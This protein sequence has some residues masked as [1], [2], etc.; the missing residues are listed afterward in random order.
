MIVYVVMGL[1][2]I[3][4]ACANVFIAIRQRYLESLVQELTRQLSRQNEQLPMLNSQATRFAM[5]A[6]R[7]VV[8]R[9]SHELSQ[10]EHNV[11]QK[12]KDADR[13]AGGLTIALLN[14]D[15][16]LRKYDPGATR[17]DSYY[18]AEEY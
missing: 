18:P 6:A 15:T 5:E 9:R 7:R 11:E 4:L 17:S 8:D 16:E 12:F 2:I 1:L 13:I 10:M 14:V 3:L